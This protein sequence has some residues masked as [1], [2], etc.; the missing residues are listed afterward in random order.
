MNVGMF[1]FYV[2]PWQLLSVHQVAQ[3]IS[4]GV[5]FQIL[6]VSHTQKNDQFM[7][8]LM[9]HSWCQICLEKINNEE[10]LFQAYNLEPR[11]D[12]MILRIQA[13]LSSTCWGVNWRL[14]S[15]VWERKA[16]N[17]IKQRKRKRCDS[18]LTPNP[19]HCQQLSLWQVKLA[20]I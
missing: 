19:K 14:Y 9:Y 16:E 6:P 12:N 5:D 3:F 8:S 11:K 17:C 1:L 18:M 10:R 2:Y 7:C 4:Q 20:D 15:Y 13:H